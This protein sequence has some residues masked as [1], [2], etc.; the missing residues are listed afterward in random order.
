MLSLFSHLPIFRSLSPSFPILIGT[1]LSFLFL[2]LFYFVT[3]I[4]KKKKIDFIL[5]YTKVSILIIL[6]CLTWPFYFTVHLGDCSLPLCSPLVVWLYHGLCNQCHRW[7]H[8]L[9]NIT[10]NETIFFK[11]VYLVYVCPCVLL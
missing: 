2:L 8:L 10:N 11:F 7:I 4:P 1:L 3:I 6:F 9:F 5:F